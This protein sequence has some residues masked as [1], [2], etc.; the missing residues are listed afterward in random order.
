[1]NPSPTIIYVTYFSELEK[2]NETPNFT[3][4][5]ATIDRLKEVDINVTLAI[6]FA[7]CETIQR[8]SRIIKKD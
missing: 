4:D 8:R 1:M 3:G 7:E 6:F 2:N 5:S